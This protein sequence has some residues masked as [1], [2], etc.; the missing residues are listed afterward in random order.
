ML[1]RGRRIGWRWPRLPLASRAALYA[2]ATTAALST[3]ALVVLRPSHPIEQLV[4]VLPFLVCTPVT[5][6]I[7]KRIV[8]NRARGLT[9][10][11]LAFQRGEIDDAEPLIVDPEFRASRLLFLNLA[12]DLLVATRALERRDAERRRLFADVVHEIGTP[13]SSLLGLADA[14]HRPELTPTAEARARLVLAVSEQS[15]R[16]ARFVEDL[17]DIA[18]LDDPAMSLQREVV[19]LGALIRDVL[20]RFAASSVERDTFSPEGASTVERALEVDVR[21]R[22]LLDV[23]PTRIE[24]VLVNLLTNAE[25]YAPRTAP[26]RV[27]LSR[28]DEAVLLVV[29]DGGPGVPEEKLPLLGERMRRLDPARARSLGGSGLG[30]SIVG[31]IVDRHGGSVAYDR[32]PLGGL[33]VTLQLP[34]PKSHRD[35]SG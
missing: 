31:A 5:Y 9:D 26:I 25:R 2:G 16:L 20:E 11:Y 19:D 17:R 18:Q 4:L 34:S 7:T 13:V 8:A 27:S 29:E 35:R 10:A 33:R 24:Q 6:V 23:D 1:S 32:S 3:L 15:E 30:L 14:L 22:C 28:E 12:R 21:E